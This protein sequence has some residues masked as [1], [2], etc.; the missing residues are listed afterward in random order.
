MLPD[1]LLV[2]TAN[3][4]KLEEI[5]AVLGPILPKTKLYSLRDLK[6][7]I[8][9][10]A[11]VGMT[12]EANA[13]IKAREYAAASGLACLADDS[14][15][16][17]DALGGKPGVISS[18]YCTDGREVGMSREERDAANNQRVLRE[19][20]NITQR[21]ARFVCVLALYVPGNNV[22]LQRGECVGS[23]GLPG[24]VPSGKD[25]F[26]YDPLFLVGGAW[27]ERRTSAEL[28][29]QEKNDISHRGVALRAL[30]EKMASI[31]QSVI[32]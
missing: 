13:T 31:G 23:I 5:E 17:I 16:E 7:S 10:P 32:T 30:A 20:Q 18:H 6:Q 29:Q 22:I 9:E 14:G 12:F 25:G 11:E 19:M 28:T 27:Q 24:R 15:L 3:L 2:A 21:T 4:H 1:R 26:G 8:P